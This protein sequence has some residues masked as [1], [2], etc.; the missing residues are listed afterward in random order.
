MNGFLLINKPKGIT[1]F[2]VIRKVRKILGVRKIG[3]AGTLDP[4]ATG[5]LLLA[6]GEGTKL[7]EYLIQKDKT[8][9]AEIKLGAISTTYDAEGEITQ[10][11]FQEKIKKEELEKVIQK[12]FLGKIQQVPPKYSALKINGQ[13]AYD[14]ARRGEEVKLQAREVE[15]YRNEILKYD[16]PDLTLAIDCSTGT[17]IRSIANDLG[18]KLGCGGY[19]TKLERTRV[20]KFDLADALELEDVSE[21]EILSLEWG[22][23]GFQIIEIT[24]QAKKALRFG[25]QI[26]VSDSIVF[27]Q[28]EIVFCLSEGKLISV[29]QFLEKE[30][31]LKPVKNFVV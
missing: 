22:I 17:Y 27:K 29:C 2:D 21:K 31:K 3:H 6:I 14:L 16:F 4:M 11:D 25:Q 28:E 10:S 26:E 9:L 12:S 20:G 18:E 5:L 7:L 24:E 8:Y 1:S 15:I 23:E 19:L 30:R 13:K